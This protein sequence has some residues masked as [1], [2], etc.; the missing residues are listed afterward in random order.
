MSSIAVGGRRWHFAPLDTATARLVL[1]WRYPPP[2]DFYNAADT[3][4]TSGLMNPAYHYYAVRDEQGELVAFRCFGEDARVPGGNYT[5]PALDMGGGLR[6]HLTGQGLGPLVLRAALVF[7]RQQF[8]PPAFR[9][10]VA[11]W[12]TRA[13]RACEA[14]GYRETAQFVSPWKMAFVMLMRNNEEGHHDP[15]GDTFTTA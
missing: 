12:N 6:P 14:C 7:G 8:A 9:T 11:A 5:A 1:A 2:Y 10:T 4:D 13:R 3:D 15:T